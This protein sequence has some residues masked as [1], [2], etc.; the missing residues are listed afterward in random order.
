MQITTRIC[1][2]GLAAVSA[3]ALWLTA[4]VTARAADQT[5]TEFRVG[6]LGGENEADRLRDRACLRERLENALGVPVKMFPSADYAG[7]LEGLKSGTLDYAGLG[8]SGYAAIWLE[9]PDAVEPI[10]TGQQTDGATGYYSVL[11]ARADSGIRTIEDMK[12]KRLGFADPNSTSGFL[13]PSVAF[14]NMGID[15][16]SYFASA[17]FSG[18]HEQNV[19]AVLNGDVDGGVTWTSGVGDWDDGYSNGNLHKMVRKGLLDMGDIVEVW[20]S[21]LIPNGPVV[22]RTTLPDSVKQTVKDALLSLPQDDPGCMERAM[23]GEMKGL[24]EVD[25]SFYETIVEAR[26]RKIEKKN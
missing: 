4:G 6:I 17:T 10:L 26:R 1:A 16:D 21:P 14:E 25:H 11:V 23:A 24:I 13:V 8:A 18:G 15:V 19:L 9:D 20:R 3:A 22:L 7:T 2:A 5:I 12:G